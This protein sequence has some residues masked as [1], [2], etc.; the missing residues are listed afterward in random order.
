MNKRILVLSNSWGG[1]HSFR[2]E[3]FQ[4]LVDSGY[5]VFISCPFD[6]DEIKAKW[7]ESIGCKLIE[8]VFN[9]QGTNPVADFKLM[10][11]YR[12][13][14]KKIKPL[15]VLS[16]TIKPNLYGGMAC[17]LSGVPQIANVTGLGAAVE[18]SGMMQKLTILLYK[19]GLRKTYKT[20]FQNETNM[21]FC[22]EHRMVNENVSLIP[23]SG[24]NLQYHEQ[25]PFPNDGEPIGFVF[26]SRIRY[27]KGIEEYIAAAQHCFGKGYNTE[28]IVLG[29]CEGD[30][31][32]RLKDL[33]KKGVLKYV[34]PQSDVRPF[35]AQG[36][37]T[38]HPTFYP[39]GMSNV[40]L[41]SCATGRAVITTNR[42][43][44]REIVND[45][46]NGFIVNQQDSNDL[47]SKV[48]KFIS[49]SYEERKAMGEVAR[50]KV[51][52]EFDRQIVVNAYLTEI[53]KIK[54]QYV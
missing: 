25:K 11:T 13:L 1:L 9:R 35:F 52:R 22:K 40:L 33:T 54:K 36:Q 27:E 21:K 23:G 44:C 45:G 46:M 41:E 6:N 42:P 26:C 16:Y 48:E 47:I 39:E 18:Y 17:A 8:T 14:I 19:L 30:Y 29:F 53:E 24:V 49:L 50:K 43:G 51:E 10:L 3:V 5:E 32:A 7:F 28:F 31:E 12:K 20:F 34:G 38:I 4:A 37:C 15:V 2:K